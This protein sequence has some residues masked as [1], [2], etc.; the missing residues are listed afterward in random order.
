MALNEKPK[1]SVDRAPPPRETAITVLNGNGVTG[2][3]GTASYAALPA[4]RT[5]WSTRPTARTRTHPTGTTSR[6]GSTTTSPRPGQLPRRRRSPPSSAPQDVKPV[7]AVIKG[8]S[9]GAML[10]VIVGQ[11]FH[12]TL[13]EAPVDK[14]PQRQPPNVAPGAEASLAL[15]RERAR[16][17]PFKVMVPTVLERSSWIDRERPIRMY[18]IDPDGKHKTIRLTY[19]T[20]CEGVLGRPDDRLGRSSRALGAELHPLDRRAKLRA[21]LH[22]PEA[23]HGRAPAGRRDVLGRE[24]AARLALERDDA[25]DRQGSQAASTESSR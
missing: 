21:P 16:K 7:N 18:R 13:A 19:R 20:G 2:S 5:R 8:L 23:A 15:L 22:R 4:R 6:P 17:V 25:R 11:T 10:T 14:T 1:P 9:N 24:H 3:A 12:G